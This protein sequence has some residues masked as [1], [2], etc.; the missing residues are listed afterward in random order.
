MFALS[1]TEIERIDRCSLRI[2]EEIGIRV[3]D[4]PLRRRAISAG[5]TPGR[6]GDWIRMPAA[7]VRKYVALAPATANFADCTGKVTPVGPGHDSTFWTG[8]A[9][10]YVEGTTSRAIS[11][12][13]LSEF[14]RVGDAIDTL[15][16]T[17]G[18]SLCDVPPQARDVVGLRVMA[19][20]TRKHLR[21]LLFN[22]ANVPAMVE[23]A[24]I[25]AGGRALRDGSPVSFGYSCL[26]PLHW[27]Q[28]S[29][30]LWQNSGGH[31]IPLTINGEPIAGATS[32]VT[33]AGSVA[34]SNA[35]ILAGVVLIQLLEEGRPVIHNLGFAH[36]LDMR[37]AACLSGS[38]ECAMMA[39]AGARLAAYYNLPSASWMCTDSMMDD[40][41]SSMEKMLT[42]LA[43]VHGGV[44]VIWGM[45]QVETQKALSPV[46]LVMD[47]EV[48]LAAR[49]M[50]AGFAVNED[51]LA[52][53][54][55]RDVVEGGQEFISHE[56]TLA[57]FRQELSNSPL[58]NR[59]MRQEWERGGS[60]AFAD[61]ARQRVKDIL[62]A[63]PKPCLTD[64]QRKDIQKVE[65]RVLKAW[66]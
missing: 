64:Q 40:E 42:G 22:A 56:H 39:W 14:V 27:S 43:H 35:E 50:Q 29:V 53:D 48:A 2:L 61:R 34:L 52:W 8:A 17:V 55:I 5:A 31:R 58:L 6:G 63:P 3:D 21:P 19:T 13:D 26:S 41:Q 65:F 24:E 37:S 15:F 18:T 59:T 28:I 7:M 66:Q 57:H 4:E 30:D 54:A 32:P 46:Q 23:I 25:L 9:L 62:V 20:H 49:R 44:S 45:G 1:G 33:L 38:A 11:T 60:T 12:K 51:T 47:H 16:A 10:N 36:C